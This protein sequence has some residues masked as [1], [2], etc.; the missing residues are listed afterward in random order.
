VTSYYAKRED[1]SHRIGNYLVRALLAGSTVTIL[2]GLLVA[3]AL[4][5]SVPWDLGLGTLL[6]SVVNLH[7]FVL[8]GAI[9]KLRDGRVA[10]LLLK[11]APPLPAS[12]PVQLAPATRFRWVMAVLGLIALSIAGADNWL[13]EVVIERAGEDLPRMA[14][15]ARWLGWI[16]R[17]SPVVHTR[18]A[19]KL[20]ERGEA[21]AALAEFQRSVEIYPTA[22]AWAG[23]GYLH[24][25][26]ERWSE[27][28]AA[29]AAA[30]AEDPD[31][32]P[33]LL[34]SSR[35]AVWLGHPDQARAALEHARTLA[36]DNAE[37]EQLLG[38]LPSQ[39]SA[40]QRDG[41]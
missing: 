13:R 32:I 37:V 1:P 12:D 11:D 28:S 27:A 3:P 23:I 14:D 5:G 19:W 6:I 25:R 36:P 22:Y 21:E 4:L 35:V 33:T 16:G 17:D 30:L 15:G 9:W 24:A 18:L 10:R 2:P 38:E 26:H 40:A 31:N 8:D 34:N 41:S 39:A 20:E 7:H 29:F